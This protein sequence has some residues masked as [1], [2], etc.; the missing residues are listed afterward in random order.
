VS[1]DDGSATS[2]WLTRL[3]RRLPNGMRRVSWLFG[4]WSFLVMVF[5][6]VPIL[7]LITWSFNSANNSTK[8][9]GFTLK[10]Y[11][12][13]Y[14]RCMLDLQSWI[15]DEPGGLWKPLSDFVGWA[16]ADRAPEALDPKLI[17]RRVQGPIPTFVTALTNSLIIGVISTIGAVALGTVSAW[18]TF[19]YKFPLHNALNTFVAVPM[20]V[21]EII[22]G[23]SLLSF[24]AISFGV[25]ESMGF[26]PGLGYATV[27]IAHITFSFPY[28][29]ITIQARLAGIDP[30][31]EEA[32]MDLGA[33]PAT[34]F[35]KVIIPYLLP[36]IISG[37][38][39]AFTLSLDDFIVTY[40]TYSSASM[41]LPIAIYG[42]IKGPPAML[43]VVSTIMIVITV[44]MVLLAE[45]IKWFSR[46]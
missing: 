13:F 45:G 33:T 2:F 42:G 6:Y 7:I 12:A 21:P 3:Y 18:L 19:K 28:V 26:T 41:T 35:R 8:W 20:I 30:A 5:L 16:G 25:L 9:E 1:R 11:D 39:M 15:G 10:W 14:S 34:A 38:L 27:L 17:P 37:A 24:F 44:L 31:L 46:A 23:V 4:G 29:M 40:F 43:H 32:A 36:A 22:M